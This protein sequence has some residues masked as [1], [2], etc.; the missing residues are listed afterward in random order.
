MKVNWIGHIY[1]RKCL[2][3]HAIEGKT[4]GRVDVTGRQRRR[5]MQLFDG[6]KETLD[7]GILEE[8]PLDCTLW[9]TRFGRGYGPV[10][11]LK[12]E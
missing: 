3:K 10:I 9:R 6:L 5:H 12:N 4:E 8:E 11:R 2:M 1:R 7:Y